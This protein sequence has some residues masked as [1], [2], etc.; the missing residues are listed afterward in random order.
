[1]LLNR[2]QELPN[3]I[4]AMIPILM[5][6]Q[7]GLPAPRGTPFRSLTVHPDSFRR[8]MVWMHRLGYRGLSMRELVPYLAGQKQGKVFG[9][10]FDDGFRNV[11]EHA[12]PVLNKLGFTS[13]NYF[14]VHQAGGTNVWDK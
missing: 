6:H 8:Q 1:W 5:Y 11:Y 9:I 12:L 4:S 7:V 3:M 14:V 13:T 10:T 2:R